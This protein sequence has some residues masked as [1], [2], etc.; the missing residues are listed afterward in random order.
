MLFVEGGEAKFFNSPEEMVKKAKYYLK[1]DTACHQIA[2][3]GSKRCI[4][5]GYDTDNVFGQMDIF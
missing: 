4:S 3:R 2:E 1:N 5:S